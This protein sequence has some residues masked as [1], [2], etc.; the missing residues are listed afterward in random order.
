MMR[1][2]SNTLKLEWREWLTEDGRQCALCGEAEETLEHFLLECWRLQD[3]RNKYIELQR[4]MNE[5]KEIVM[6]DVLLYNESEW[7]RKEYFVDMLYELWRERK[8][9]IEERSLERETPE[10]S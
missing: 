5:D 3:V 8:R 1:T 9:N 6:A 4:P 2:R 7:T 10:H